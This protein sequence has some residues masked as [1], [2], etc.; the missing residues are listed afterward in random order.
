MAG[1]GCWADGDAGWHIRT[2]EWILSHHAVPR[3]DLY[4]F[5]KPGAPW[6]A[7][8]WLSDVFDAVLF[9]YAGLKGVVLAA[10]V[11]IATFVT[12]VIRRMVSGGSH[13]LVALAVALLGEGASSIHFL[14]RPHIFTLLLMSISMWLIEAD[15][16]Q[17]S[18]WIWALVPI[19][20]VWTNLHG[21]F[22]ALIAVTGL[23][24]AGSAIEGRWRD[25]FRYAGLTCAC[26]AV[27]L[28]NPYGYQLHVHVIQ[29]LRSDWIRNMI[30]EFQSP[31][32][33]DETMMQFELLLFSGLIAAGVMFRKRQVVEGL[34]IL[35]FAHMALSS[36]RHVP[37]YVAA[38]APAIAANL[39]DWYRGW[40]GQ[41][42]KNSIPGILNQIAED[43]SRGFR[44]ESVWPALAIVVLALM[45]TL[46]GYS[47]SYQRSRLPSPI[48]RRT[49]T[50]ESPQ[51]KRL[52]PV[53]RVELSL[54]E[55][56]VHRRSQAR[57]ALLYLSGRAAPPCE[58][59]W[60]WSPYEAVHSFAQELSRR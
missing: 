16:R 42:K 4:S 50:V 51:C 2:G 52:P 41:A 18:R 20:V 36:V 37:L 5:S 48:R 35:F 45:E 46:S 39:S 58:M 3:H 27:T 38:C 12:T 43:A 9:K 24:A 23:T 44:R 19:T 21:G 29:Y 15:R 32:F 25:G 54:R 56:A 1:R 11:I 31:S 10:G 22:L 6:Y 55:E 47:F 8:E 60:W 30:Q 34:W 26:A 7:W 17:A 28:V 13:I 49:C 57:D 53:L 14:A 59:R 33:R 40:T